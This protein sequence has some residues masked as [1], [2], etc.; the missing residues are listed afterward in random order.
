MIENQI[1]NLLNFYIVLSNVIE[2]DE[3]YIIEKYIKWIGFKP[4]VDLGLYTHDGLTSPILK[5]CDKW[6]SKDKI[7]SQ[8]KLRNILFFLYST[9]KTS[10]LEYIIL[11]FEKYIGPFDLIY[12]EETNGVHPNL[13]HYIDSIID[14]HT[15]FITKFIRDKKID[16]INK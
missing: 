10:D 7:L 15:I 4:T 8:S 6:Y 14:G 12:N 1:R 16:I 5:W 13:V 2:H 3:D 9:N 11:S